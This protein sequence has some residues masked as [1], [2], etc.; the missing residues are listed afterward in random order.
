MAR[1]KITNLLTVT[2]PTTGKDSDSAS[3]HNNFG[4]DANTN[5]SGNGT[6]QVGT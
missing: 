5:G 1:N 6:T 3:L 4:N 2:Q